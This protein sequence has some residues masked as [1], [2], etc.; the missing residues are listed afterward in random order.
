MEMTSIGSKAWARL[1]G[2]NVGRPVAISLDNIVYSAPNVID[3]ITGGSTEISG[4]F[5]VQEAQDLADLLQSGK[6][7]APAKIVAQQVVGPT[8]GAESVRGG[9]IVGL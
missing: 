6:V 9:A 8:L 7:D 5:T 4:S 1:T 3:A 2:K